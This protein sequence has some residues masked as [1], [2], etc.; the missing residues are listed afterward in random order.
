MQTHVHT[1]PRHAHTSM[2]VHTRNHTRTQ[3]TA[4]TTHRP[5]HTH[6]HRH[7]HTHAADTH[8]HDSGPRTCT[9]GV[10][11]GPTHVLAHF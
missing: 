7:I 2:H 3:T 4:G 9:R 1:C 10:G 5:L 8:E 6:T 11:T